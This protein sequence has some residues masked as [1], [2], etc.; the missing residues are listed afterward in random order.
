MFTYLCTI[1]IVLAFG[2]EAL[3]G[4]GGG[5]VAVPLLSLVIDVRE[6]VVLVSI[7]QFFVGFLIFKSYRSVAWSLMPPL[8]LGMVGGVIVGVYSLSVM[9]LTVLRFMLATFILAFLGRTYFASA[10]A[11]E[12][13]SFV[14]GTVSGFFGGFFQG[15]L[16]TGGPN[17]VIY[18]KKL[19]P[20]PKM[21]RATMIFWLS[22]ANII[23]IPFTN[24]GELYTENVK[25]LAIQIFPVFLLTILIGQVL[26]HKI[27]EKLYFKVVHIFLLIAAITLVVKNFI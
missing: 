7:F 2:G 13:P 1:V 22:L 27:S 9:N 11:I 8:I 20:D 3:F 6:S 16:S 17:L 5:L 25:S 14:S 10:L 18:L 24:Q 21:F 4:F 26:H 23:R 19:V 12:K 15:C